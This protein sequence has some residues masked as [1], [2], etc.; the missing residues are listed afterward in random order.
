MT[1]L[2][3]MKEPLIPRVVSDVIAECRAPTPLTR[4]FAPFQVNA[5]NQARQNWRTPQRLGSDYLNDSAAVL[6]DLGE[7]GR[8]DP[9]VRFGH[10]VRPENHGA[11]LHD[12]IHRRL[13]RIGI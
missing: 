12:L 5:S 2:A 13:E 10:A 9:L 3:I 8:I 1:S 6:F 7:D 4:S 11:A